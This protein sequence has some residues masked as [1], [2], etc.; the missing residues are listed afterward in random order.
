[1]LIDFYPVT[2]HDI[3]I[4]GT[5]PAL[6]KITLGIINL[7]VPDR[8]NDIQNTHQEKHQNIYND[9]CSPPVPGYIYPTAQQ[10]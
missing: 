2:I 5:E 3:L 4:F 7:T 9:A 8:D 6:F 10:Q 1:M